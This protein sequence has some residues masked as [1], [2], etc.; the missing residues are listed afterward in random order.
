MGKAFEASLRLLKPEHIK[1]TTW[2]QVPLQRKVMLNPVNSSINI[3]SSTASDF[4]VVIVI[5]IISAQFFCTYFHTFEH[6]RARL[7][8]PRHLTV[9]SASFRIY[10]GTNSRWVKRTCWSSLSLLPQG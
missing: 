7:P 10:G 6:A 9:S 1:Q 3:D 5:V 8:S 4:T 2:Q